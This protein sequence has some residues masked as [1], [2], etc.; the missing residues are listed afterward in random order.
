M[1]MKKKRIPKIPINIP[2]QQV[3]LGFVLSIVFLNLIKNLLLFFPPQ[4]FFLFY[5]VFS[6][7]SL[8]L[9]PYIFPLPTL[10]SPKSLFFFQSPP[11]SISLSFLMV[12]LHFL[13]KTLLFSKKNYSISF[14]PNVG[15]CSHILK[16]LLSH[17]LN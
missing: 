6:F 15:C 7:F 13:T 14:L 5:L 11:L 8:N 3:Q 4:P 2:L 17:V 12:F 16:T 9:S 10:L 1:K